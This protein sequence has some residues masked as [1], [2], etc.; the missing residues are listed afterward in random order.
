[1]GGFVARAIRE[2]NYK[3][4]VGY[5]VATALVGL[6][7][8]RNVHARDQAQSEGFD[9]GSRNIGRAKTVGFA[10][11]STLLASPLGRPDL[12]TGKLLDTGIGATVGMAIASDIDMHM[13]IKRQRD[14]QSDAEVI[15]FVSQWASGANGHQSS[16]SPLSHRSYPRH[17]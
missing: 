2:K 11:V 6:R 5:G 1:M 13:H 17:L 4:A 14:E 8:I 10:I 16:I 3:R 9:T 12:P 15:D 7:D